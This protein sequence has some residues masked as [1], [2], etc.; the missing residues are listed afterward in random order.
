MKFE[1]PSL[2]SKYAKVNVKLLIQ[3]TKRFLTKWNNI[4]TFQSHSPNAKFKSKP[5]DF[6]KIIYF[7]EFLVG[8][9]V[10]WIIETTINIKEEML[11]GFC[12]YHPNGNRTQI[13]LSIQQ[14]TEWSFRSLLYWANCKRF[15]LI[16]CPF[17]TK[18]MLYVHLQPNIIHQISS[19]YVI[20]P[21]NLY[22]R[23]H[24]IVYTQ[25]HSCSRTH[26]RTHLGL[27]LVKIELYSRINVINLFQI[28]GNLFRSLHSLFAK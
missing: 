7:I 12:T 11:Y 8:L 19:N 28:I 18:P 21:L 25:P 1:I 2:K 3:A 9:N 26:T 27:F 5:I 20:R 17:K 4:A 13:N 15:R 14:F 16:W 6:N 24:K 22:T 23:T 10:C